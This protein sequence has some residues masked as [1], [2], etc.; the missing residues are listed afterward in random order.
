MKL[1]FLY[2]DAKY[3][4]SKASTYKF[5]NGYEIITVPILSEIAN[6]NSIKTN[7][8]SGTKSISDSVSPFVGR[9]KLLI[10]PRLDGKGYFTKVLQ[11]LP[12]VN[13]VLAYNNKFSADNFTGYVSVWN[14]ET[15][16]KK[17]L[18]YEN[19][20]VGSP[21]SINVDTVKKSGFKTNRVITTGRTSANI[22]RPTWVVLPTVTVT[23]TR[24]PSTDPNFG[25]TMDISLEIGNITLTQ[26]LFDTPSG[27]EHEYGGSTSLE[28]V[29]LIINANDLWY[30]GWEGGVANSAATIYLLYALNLNADV[31]YWIAGYS[32]SDR[33][34]RYLQNSTDINA[35]QKAIDHIN[36]MCNTV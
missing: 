2:K 20:K 8:R 28:D 34:V 26:T 12:T 19:A 17:G 6:V 18:A 24:K 36:L 25:S 35:E 13:Y 14:L 10:Y 31:L 32:H 9:E 30:Y 21:I 7:S 27:S 22:I 29:S 33:I 5:K 4:W 1:H 11:V 23:A 3:D 16:F 15:G